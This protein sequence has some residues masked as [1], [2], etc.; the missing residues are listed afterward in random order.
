MIQQ[1]FRLEK[2]R[3]RDEKIEQDER[4]G[5]ENLEE[6][7]RE[8]ETMR[9]KLNVN[10]FVDDEERKELRRRFMARRIISEN[11]NQEEAERRRSRG[12]ELITID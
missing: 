12:V 2:R 1:N 9:K 3:N 5:I 11:N 7:R 4:I 10:K 6:W 8:M